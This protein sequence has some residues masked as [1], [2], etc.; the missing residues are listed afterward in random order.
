MPMRSMRCKDILV[1]CRLRIVSAG[2]GGWSQFRVG[3]QREH[4]G[5]NPEASLAAT[6]R[7]RGGIDF[8][9]FLTG[10]V[11]EQREHRG[12]TPEARLAATP[13]RRGGVDFLEFL[14]GVF[15]A[16]RYYFKTI[17][18]SEQATRPVEPPL[19]NSTCSALGRS[20]ST[21]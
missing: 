13:R 16:E 11:G 6:A 20:P 14:T 10:V 7:R 15:P 12:V 1:W 17:G 9:E 2:F 8:L 5:V 4:R 18:R 3:E 21:I 19:L